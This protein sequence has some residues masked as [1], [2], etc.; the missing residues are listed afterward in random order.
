MAKDGNG[1]ANSNRPLPR[2]HD[3]EQSVLGSM[4]RDNQIISDVIVELRA[5]HLFSDAHQ[6][7]YKAILK[8]F[9][10]GRPVD[11]VTLAEELD[12]EKISMILVAL[13]IS[14]KFGTALQPPLTPNSMR[15]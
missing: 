11:L 13:R 15:K 9:D 4:L 14:W 2:S 12:L 5:E 3:A 8:L 1:V 10:T 6:R 7:I